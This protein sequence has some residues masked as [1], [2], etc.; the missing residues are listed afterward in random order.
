MLAF[1]GYLRVFSA[2]PSGP[3]LG[4]RVDWEA[5][6]DATVHRIAVGEG[7]QW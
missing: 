1:W 4:L 6:E 5:M 3:G 7:E 2:A